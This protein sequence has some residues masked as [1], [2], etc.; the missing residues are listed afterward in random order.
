MN[1]ILNFILSALLYIPITT[2]TTNN[3]FVEFNNSACIFSGNSNRE[4]AQ[5]VADHL[6]SPLGKATVGKFNDSEIQIKIE[7]SVRN[8]DVYIIQ[9]TCST[10]TQSVNDNFVELCLLI[11]TMKRSSAA[12]ITIVMP[13]FGYARQ[14]RKTKSRVP[15]SAADVAYLLERSGAD[16]VI[17][18][19]LHCGQI[20]GFFQNIP[21]DNLC[22]SVPFSHYIAEKKLENIVVVSPDVGGVERANQ[23]IFE[24]NKKGISAEL[25]I[26]SKQRPSAGEIS[27][28]HL[29]GNVKGLNAII[30]DDM[31]DTGGT[32]VKAAELIKNSGATR[33][34]AAVTHPVFSGNALT[35]IADSVIDEMIIADTIPLHGQIPSNINIIS[36]AP[37][38]ANAILKIQFNESLS[39]L[40]R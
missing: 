35:T 24:L 27:A 7:E 32:L 12:S 11:R 39:V 10:T 8:K 5:K 21:V 37:L 38:L 15:I 3:Q 29:I 36:V 18:V 30:I 34:F 9:S 16:R 33:V 2:W 31:C 6:H 13:Y 1:K 4:L 25:A 40:F 20:Q 19:D 17:T 28:M 26:I 23:F 22:A 14:D